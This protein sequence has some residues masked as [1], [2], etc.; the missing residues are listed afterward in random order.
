MTTELSEWKASFDPRSPIIIIGAG[1]SGSTWLMRLLDHQ[2]DVSLKGETNFLS[3]RLWTE[4]WEDRF[5]HFWER[6][7]AKHPQSAHDAPPVCDDD[8]LEEEKER[9]GGIVAKAVAEVLGVSPN[10]RYWGLKEIWNGCPP[11]D[12]EWLPY[13]FVYPRAR[14]VHLVRHPLE[15]A[16]SCIAWNERERSVPVVENHLRQWM[17]IVERS[18][19]RRSTGRFVTVRYEDLM[20]DA[21]GTLEGIAA[22]LDLRGLSF[23]GAAIVESRLLDSKRDAAAERLIVEQMAFIPALIECAAAFGYEDLIPAKW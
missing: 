1:R 4:I 21:R 7:V 10:A 5:W 3:C 17:K 11:N 12:Y 20:R 18:E 8:E 6:Y 19:E 2:A 9:A 23:D 13:D 22:A 15:F 14:W 16:F